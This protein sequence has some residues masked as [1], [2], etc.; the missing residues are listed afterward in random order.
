MI[1]TDSEARTLRTAVFGAMVLV[2]TAEPGA[3]DQESHAGIRALSTFSPSL[4]E[5]LSAAHPELPEGTV[6]D[7]EAGVLDA[8]RRSAAILSTKAPADARAFPEAV[9]SICREVATA[10]GHVG[11]DEHAVITR[12]REAL[13]G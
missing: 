8:L 2:S 4:R 3:L 12:V 1:Y 11:E 5:V 6:A 7:V 13:A 10:D 9:L